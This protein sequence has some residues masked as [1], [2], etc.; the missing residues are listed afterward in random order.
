MKSDYQ[1]GSVEQYD[2]RMGYGYIK[3]DE[4]ASEGERILVHRRSLRISGVPLSPGD[5]VIFKPELVPRGLLAADVHFE[6][7]DPSSDEAFQGTISTLHPDRG[8]GFIVDDRLDQI[9]FH[10]SQLADQDQPPPIGSN[11]SFQ[12]QQTARG[13]QAFRVAPLDTP[14][15]STLSRDVPQADLPRKTT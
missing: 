11:V 1:S 14:I 8:F 3:P 5:R 15:S 10:F 2:D 7:V 13:M 9:F 4:P 12:K 6:Q